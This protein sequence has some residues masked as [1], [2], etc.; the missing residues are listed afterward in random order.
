MAKTGKTKTNESDH[1]LDLINVQPKNAKAII[2]AARLYKE[3][4][5][6]RQ[7]ALG[8]EVEQKQ[9]VLDLVKAA[10][11]QPLDGGKIKFEY[12]GVLICVTPRDELIT[13]KDKANP[14]CE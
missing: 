7:I 8:K 2:R 13:V 10:K 1:Q 3:F 12:D 11:L 14:G 5:G 9:R 4:Q 6:A